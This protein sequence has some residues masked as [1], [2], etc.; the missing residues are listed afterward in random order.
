VQA[1]ESAPSRLGYYRLA[2]LTL[3]AVGLVISRRPDAIFHAQFYAEDGTV[4]FAQA[5][6][7][8]I[9]RSFTIVT[10]QGG[11]QTGGYLQA[12]PRLVAAVSMVL[13]LRLVPLLFNL[14]GLAF[15]LAPAL[16][17]FT[18]RFDHVVPSL[19]GKALLAL[20]YVAL[21]SAAELHVN[22]TNSQWHLALLALLVLVAGPPSPR[23]WKAFDLTTLLLCGLS[24][25]FCLLLAPIAG[26]R[27]LQIRSRLLGTA[28]L[29][30]V[31]CSLLQILILRS[32]TRPLGTHLEASPGL[33]VHILAGRVFVSGLV[34]Q[35]GFA[36]VS[37][38]QAWSSHLVPI[39]VLAAGIALIGYAVLR[40]TSA[41]RLLILYGFLVLG[42]GLAQVQ[43][44]MVRLGGDDRYFALAILGLLA[45][46]VWSVGRT[47]SRG[48]RAAGL[49]GLGVF[50]VVG[51]PADWNYPAFFD[52]GFA[53]QAD[54]F[55]QLPAGQ[56]MTFQLNPAGWSM[57]L[58]KRPADRSRSLFGTLVSD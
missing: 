38:T 36:V 47:R 23:R 12:L 34:G 27:W 13:P 52:T 26:I 10:S 40:G 3:F 53:A 51:M 55:S 54:A 39:L 2:L 33:L 43:W 21:P 58:N 41:L 17:L 6:N 31:T 48:A 30:L 29:V 18:G 25:P 22:L 49:A 24:G 45:V 16:F 56:Q 15:L 9:L 50:L 8:G 11:G 32:Q 42:A 1:D 4:W 46:L 7:E 37:Q 5:Y 57:T 35:Q 28:T 14:V 44:P 19:W 20:V